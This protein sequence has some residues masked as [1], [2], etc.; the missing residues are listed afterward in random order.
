MPDPLLCARCGRPVKRGGYK[1]VIIYTEVPTPA[2]GELDWQTPLR[3]PW[4]RSAARCAP[5]KKVD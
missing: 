4:H 2:Q 3:V 5:A 1:Y